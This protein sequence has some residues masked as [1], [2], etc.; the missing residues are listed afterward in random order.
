MLASPAIADSHALAICALR[1]L[2]AAAP[3]A[4]HAR[5]ASVLAH[6]TVHANTR[7]PRLSPLTAQHTTPVHHGYPLH[8]P[9]G[10]PSFI[11]PLQYIL[12]DLIK[13]PTAPLNP[14]THPVVR[15]R[16]Q[17]KPRNTSASSSLLRWQ[18]AAAVLDGNIGGS[19][20]IGGGSR[21]ATRG[22]APGG[23]TIELDVTPEQL[24]NLL[25]MRMNAA[26]PVSSAS[27]PA[28]LGRHAIA[29][30][31]GPAATKAGEQGS[32]QVLAATG[33]ESHH[34]CRHASTCA[35][36]FTWSHEGPKDSHVGDGSDAVAS[37]AAAAAAAIVGMSALLGLESEEIASTKGISSMDVSNILCFC[38]QL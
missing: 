9:S 22:T 26:T 5:H 17:S 13:P 23:R 29:H 2:L 10:T 33:I 25:M 24:R 35:V 30:T 18:Q 31:A 12:K 32:A 27:S 37:A 15:D 16:V 7:L 28:L 38:S 14:Q 6:H 11:D 3:A 8:P 34:P 21:S 36:D 19:G 4:V 1:R 20:G